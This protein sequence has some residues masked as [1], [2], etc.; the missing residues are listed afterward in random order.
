MH[1]A[2]GE[3]DALAGRPTQV[4][5]PA[6]IGALTEAELRRLGECEWSRGVIVNEGAVDSASAVK[7]PAASQP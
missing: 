1:R 7:Y 3:A 4:A 5:V 6:R 2:F